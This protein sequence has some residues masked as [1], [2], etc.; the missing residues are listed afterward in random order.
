MFGQRPTISS[1]H[2]MVACAHPHAA[3]AGTRILR[4]GGNAFD[5]A[6]AVA[7]ALNVVEPFMSGMAGLGMATVWSARDRQ[8][9]CL[10]FVSPVPERFTTDGLTHADTFSGPLASAAPGSLAGWAALSETYGNL[11]LAAAFA[12]AMELAEGGFPVGDGVVTMNGDWFDIRHQDAEWT[13][14]YTNGT[15]TVEPGWVLRQPD[16]AGT[17]L[18]V[19]ENGPAWLYDGPLGERMVAHLAANGGVLTMDDLRAVAPQWV[20]PLA[21]GYRGLQVH[22]LPPP[23][24]SFQFLLTLGALD[25]IDLAA[26]EPNGVEHLDT[27]F[28]AVRLAA[29]LR[30]TN[31]NASREMVESL[32][33]PERLTAMTEAIRSGQ[34]IEGR[35]QR[36]IAVTDPVLANSREHTTSFSTADADGNLVCVTQ[37][38]GSVYGSG[39]VIPGT[40]L[41]MNNFLNW[42][43]LDRQSPNHLQAGGRLAMCLAPSISLREGEPALA[44]GTPGSFGILQ[45]QVQAMVQFL[46]FGLGLQAAV[47]A[48][49]G[50]LFD[51]NLA[52][53]EGRID[54][55]VITALEDR[56]HAVT[57]VEDWTSRVGGL[58]A[59][60]RDTVTG[61]L[62]GAADP[63]RDGYAL[64]P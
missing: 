3:V 55:A 46:D 1:L 28:R 33:A 50:R 44:L 59:V 63:R 56:G 58:H 32:L 49:R 34:P 53:I 19:A 48:P 61:V 13:R 60:S 14:V 25:G 62:T 17:L 31:N 40:G 47:E 23:A 16:L 21:V 37:S 45:T 42:G 51:G 29:E 22:S 38:L 41:T 10:D 30:I 8:V 5:A 27:V 26:F 9:R 57:V 12:P 20:E 64:M 35:T 54:A 43:D 36:H 4:S 15:A 11:S 24:E 39:V 6:V 7:A 52:T 18:A 2:G